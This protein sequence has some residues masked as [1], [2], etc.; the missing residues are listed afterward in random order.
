MTPTVKRIG[1]FGGSFDPVHNGHLAVAKFAIENDLVD[2]VIFVPVGKPWQKQP[3]LANA[4]QR[5]T[6]LELALGGYSD[7]KISPF[8]IERGST[9]YTI[10][11]AK[12]L[13]LENPVAQIMLLLGA[14]AAA[15]L[16]SW[17]QADQLLNLVQVLVIAREFESTPILDFKFNFIKMPLIQVSSSEIREKISQ[18]ES[19]ENLVPDAVK[20][21]II[22]QNLYQNSNVR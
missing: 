13:L 2:E 1:L 14:D 10:D 7:F 21:Y 16:R 4:A 11:T 9:S 19:I 20:N 6:M 18:G 12:Q 17:H 8:E 3:P 22:N 15:G 5:L